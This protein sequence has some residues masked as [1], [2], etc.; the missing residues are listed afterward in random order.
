[1]KKTRTLQALLA[2][3]Q[4]TLGPEEFQSFS[5]EVDRLQGHYFEILN[6]EPAGAARAHATQSLIEEQ[7]AANSHI[8]TSCQKG[9]GGCCH[10]EVEIT[11][12]DAD[13]LARSILRQ[14]LTFDRARLADQAS[15]PRLDAKWSMGM[16]AS[17]RCV[18]LGAD[19]ACGNYLDRPTVCR[20][21]SVTSAAELCST[22]GATPVPL[23]VPMN[24][25]IMSAAINLEGNS[26]G[27]LPKMLAA[28]LQ[29]LESGG[30]LRDLDF[31]E[32]NAAT[33][34]RGSNLDDVPA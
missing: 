19:N 9:C 20:K 5:N 26:F 31:T 10:L 21:H 22:P 7:N 28:A 32:E 6:A 25:I 16:V 33:D 27:A 2:N 11:E 17:N 12:D 23:I 30:A 29:R 3:Y 24:E 13:L 18:M 14:K 15:R 8:K 1:M 34:S 4:S